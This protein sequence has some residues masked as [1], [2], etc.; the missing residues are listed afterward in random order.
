MLNIEEMNSIWWWH[1][2]R[3]GE[4]VTPGK[5]YESDDTFDSIGFPNDLTGKTVLD[6]GC[7]DGYYSFRCE[8]LNADRVVACDSLVWDNEG[9]TDAGFNFAHKALNSKVEKLH[10]AVEVLPEKNLG[11]FD[12][13]LMLGVLYHAKNPIQ[14]MEIAR[15]LSKDIVVFET[16]MDLNEVSVPAVRYY[17][18]NELSNDDTNYWGFN[19]LAL[20]GAMK[21]IGYKDVTFKSLRNPNRIIAIGKV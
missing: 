19:K 13:V 6:I 2:I 20:A 8:Q 12:I 18:G 14:F 16:V 9:I 3:I 5:N 11:K 15:D 21:D 10:S 4:H 7:W 17:V 1:R